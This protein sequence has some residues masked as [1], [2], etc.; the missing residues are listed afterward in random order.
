MMHHSLCVS[1]HNNGLILQRRLSLPSPAFSSM[2]SHGTMKQVCVHVATF[3]RNITIISMNLHTLFDDAI[4]STS[5][6][7][8]S[9]LRY[10]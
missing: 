1:V 10:A 5:S 3:Y 2:S 9:P 8:L 7:S 4:Y 6:V